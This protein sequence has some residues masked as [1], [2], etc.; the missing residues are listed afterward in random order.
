MVWQENLFQNLLTVG[1]L[2]AMALFV[3]C[4]ITNKTLVDLIKEIREITEAP[5]EE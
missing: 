2:L 3:Y 1:I 5:V 4:R